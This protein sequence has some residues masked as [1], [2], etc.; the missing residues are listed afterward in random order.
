MTNAAAH[1]DRPA[2]GQAERDGFAFV[3]SD[4]A[5]ATSADSR[6]A[7]GTRR[8]WFSRAAL[9]G[10]VAAATIISPLS[11]AYAAKDSAASAAPTAQ[12]G[13]VGTLGSDSVDLP[14]AAALEADP[15]APTRAMTSA[16]RS[17]MREALECPVQSEANGTLSA[18]MGGEDVIPDL[19]LPAAE[20]TYRLTS[21]YGPR[22]YPFPGMHEGTD[23]AG[24]LGTP[25]YAVADGTIVY[26]GGGR[27]GRSGQIVILRAEV[28]GATYDFWYGHMYTDGVLVAEGQDVTVGQQIA[29]IGNNGNSTGPHLHFEVHDSGDQ[30]TDPYAFLQAHGAQPVGEAAACA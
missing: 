29:A 13:V 6:R 8:R 23:F 30:T 16:S 15:N 28:D 14:E 22:S 7:P 27:D 19:V 26:A 18:V 3:T 12:D 9:L 24:D 20:G 11:G 25:L 10:A 17:Y 2:A 5:A 21:D 1:T 4:E